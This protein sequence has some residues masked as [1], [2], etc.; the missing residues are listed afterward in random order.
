[1]INPMSA[2]LAQIVRGFT[3]VAKRSSSVVTEPTICSVP[4]T[5]RT[6]DQRH[7]LAWSD[8]HLVGNFKLDLGTLRP[9]DR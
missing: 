7:A 3:P 8:H 6:T 2:R 1:M 4:M 5:M 9:S